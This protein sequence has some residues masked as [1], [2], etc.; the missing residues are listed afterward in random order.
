[1]ESGILNTLVQST[2]RQRNRRFPWY[3]LSP[4]LCGVFFHIRVQVAEA[5]PQTGIDNN[6]VECFCRTEVGKC[7]SESNTVSQNQGLAPAQ[8]GWGALVLLSVWVRC[9]ELQASCPDRQHLGKPQGISSCSVCENQELVLE[10]QHT[11]PCMHCAPCPPNLALG[12]QPGPLLA[13]IEVCGPLLRVRAF[14]NIYFLSELGL[15]CCARAFSDFGEQCLLSSCS[16]W[17]SH[18][19]E[20]AC[21][22]A[23]ALGAQASV[24]AARGLSS[25]QS[26]SR[27]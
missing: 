15:C 20:F 24:G 2:P 18:C 3:H 26:L 25:V 10:S 12:Q 7:D 13:P 22:S 23:Q 8:E 4:F 17:A 19:G 5:L 16:A 14:L 9:L 27:P 1:M 21:G 6:G 11:S